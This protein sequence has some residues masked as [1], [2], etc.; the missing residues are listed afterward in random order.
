MHQPKLVWFAACGIILEN[1]NLVPV[2]TDVFCMDLVTGTCTGRTNY[3]SSLQFIILQIA[4]VRYSTYKFYY[5]NRVAC[6]YIWGHAVAQLVEALR[7]KPEGRGFD[8]RWC[9]WIFSLT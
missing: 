6:I 7:Y 5:R 1:I 8:S 3:V 4:G 2:G 9:Y